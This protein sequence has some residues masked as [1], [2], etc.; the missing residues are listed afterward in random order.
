MVLLEYAEH[1]VLPCHLWQLLRVF[2]VGDA[3]QQPVIVFLQ[4]EKINHRGVGEQRA[5]VVVHV[6]DH[7]VICGVQSAIALQQL[8][9]RGVA[10]LGKHPHGVFRRHLMAVYVYLGVYYLLHPLS[11]PRGVV[12]GNVVP[13]RQVHVVAI[14]HRYVYHHPAARVEVVHRLAENEKERAGVATRP[15]AGGHVEKFHVL[16]AVCPEVHSLNLVVDLRAYRLSG[17]FQSR[18]KKNFR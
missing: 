17:H 15:R 16:V 14:A 2:Q 8:H 13:Y 3:Q 9:L 7:L 4:S 10:L 11:Y 6:V 5:V 18:L 12:V 1:L